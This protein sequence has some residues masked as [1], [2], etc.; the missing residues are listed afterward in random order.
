MRTVG[1]KVIVKLDKRE[2]VTDG[3]III[4]DYV[5]RSASSDNREAYGEV[6]TV[7]P[8]TSKN[9]M[10]VSVGDR[11]IFDY[12]QGEDLFGDDVFRSFRVGDIMAVVGDTK[13]S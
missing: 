7:G 13:A 10:T 3:G 8:G 2:E 1:D 11:V 4:P 12:W 9:P 6:I 5:D